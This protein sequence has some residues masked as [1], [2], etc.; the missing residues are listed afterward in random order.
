MNL[1]RCPSLRELLDFERRSYDD[2]LSK[3]QRISKDLKIAN[4]KIRKK[5]Y[6][7]QSLK[8]QRWYLVSKI[9]RTED[10]FLKLNET[11]IKLHESNQARFRGDMFSYAIIGPDNG[12]RIS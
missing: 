1:S 4:A 3:S 8:R 9:K 7:I 2:L 12:L 11:I 6:L 5:K 10:N